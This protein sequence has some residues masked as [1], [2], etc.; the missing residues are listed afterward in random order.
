MRIASWKDCTEEK[1]ALVSSVDKARAG[2]LIDTTEAR[3]KAN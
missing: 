1:E 2:S 3:I